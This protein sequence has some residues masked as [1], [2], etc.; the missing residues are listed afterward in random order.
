MTTH[1]VCP[2]Q[3]DH[4]VCPAVEVGDRLERPRIAVPG[5]GNAHHGVVGGDVVQRGV[6]A[7][8]RKERPVPVGHEIAAGYA[9][10]VKQHDMHASLLI[11]FP[12]RGPNN[13]FLIKNYSY[14]LQ[15]L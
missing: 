1:D 3:D 2:A 4:D 14:K 12:E 11:P 8:L 6:A 10:W 9:H 5:P 7:P 15:K 13:F